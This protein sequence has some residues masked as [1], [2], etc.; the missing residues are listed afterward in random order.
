MSGSDPESE[1]GKRP[2]A[3]TFGQHTREVL[4]EVGLREVEIDRLVAMGVVR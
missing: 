4:L 1:Q 3:P 2:G